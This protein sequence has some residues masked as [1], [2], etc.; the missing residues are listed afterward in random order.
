M[1][2]LDH[3]VTE[4]VESVTLMSEGHRFRLDLFGRTKD[5]SAIVTWE[6]RSPTDKTRTGRVCVR[7]DDNS[8]HY[9]AVKITGSYRPALE[10]IVADLW[11]M[12]G[13]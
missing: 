6:H 13:G 11:D 10:Q 7:R 4:S 12:V 3:E 5:G 2:Y 1:C 8:C 9:H